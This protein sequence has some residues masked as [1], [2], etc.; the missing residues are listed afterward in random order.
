MI[1]TFDDLYGHAFPLL[2]MLLPAEHDKTHSACIASGVSHCFFAL[3][4]YSYGIDFISWGWNAERSAS[5]V[6]FVMIGRDGT[7]WRV[8]ALAWERR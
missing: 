1:I 7:D 2:P 4:L 8:L 3:G 6:L 5:L